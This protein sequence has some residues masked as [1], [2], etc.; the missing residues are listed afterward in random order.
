M[1]IKEEL[2]PQIFA[3]IFALTALKVDFGL[4]ICQKY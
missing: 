2:F 1:F 3:L 4:Q